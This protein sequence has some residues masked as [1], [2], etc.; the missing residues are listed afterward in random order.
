MKSRLPT[1]TVSL[2][3]AA[4]PE[5][6]QF[7]L[8][9]YHPYLDE[10]H[11]MT[12]DFADGNWGD[13]IATH[14]TNLYSTEY[15]KYSIDQSVKYYM[16]KGVPSNKIMIGVAFYSRGFANTDGLGKACNGGSPD[17]SWERGI[18]DY[19][20][21]PVQGATEMWDD[22][23]KAS[24][25]YDPKKRVLN[26]YDTV[27][28]VQE[29][30]KYVKENNLKGIIVWEASGDRDITSPKSLTKKMYE[31]LTSPISQPISEPYEHISEPEIILDHILSKP[32]KYRITITKLKE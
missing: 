6:V 1:Y 10:F 20:A 25:S 8:E 19:K 29:K 2:A 4:D 32:G 17:M 11:I 12:Y 24:Y 27:R 14:H 5:K 16:S 15:T 3:C 28:S 18:V 9:K 30:C 22:G 13:N 23:A 21:L 31:E 26:S 7:S